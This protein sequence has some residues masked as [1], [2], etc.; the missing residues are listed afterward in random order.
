ML[1][2]ISKMQNEIKTHVKECF[3]S[4]Q[5]EGPY[6]GYKQLFIRFCNCNLTCNYCDTDFL[7]CDDSYKI[8]PKELLEKI[9]ALDLTNIHS[10][11]LTGGEP[12]LEIEFL[13]KF[14]PLINEKIYLETNGTLHDKLT[15]VIDLIDIISMDIK[16]PSSSKNPDLFKRHEEFIKVCKKYE[17]D[18]FLKVV[19]DENITQYEIEK[20]IE[21]ARNNDLE[22]ILQPLMK[23]DAITTSSE[24]LI[25]TFNTFTSKYEKVRLIPQV[26]KFIK[27][28]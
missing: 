7:A 23:N 10:I 24:I 3:V 21:I 27:V 8:T 26:H 28:E 11:S 14:L 15:K 25:K 17:K 13:K 1:G 9:N 16:L 20:C 12:L 6:I 4:I 2:K 5:G 19:F 18:L 22:I